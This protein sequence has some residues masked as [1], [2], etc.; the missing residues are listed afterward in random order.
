MEQLVIGDGAGHVGG[1]AWHLLRPKHGEAEL[2]LLAVPLPDRLSRPLQQ[3]L[4]ESA[5]EATKWI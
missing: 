1:S 5:C 2:K 4:Q 3:Q